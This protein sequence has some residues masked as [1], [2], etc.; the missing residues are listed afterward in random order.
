MSIILHGFFLLTSQEN[1]GVIFVRILKLLVCV[2]TW[3]FFFF[4]FSSFTL[5]IYNIHMC[6]SSKGMSNGRSFFTVV[7]LAYS[8]TKVAKYC[9]MHEHILVH[10]LVQPWDIALMPL[11]W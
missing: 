5:C 4:L 6:I 1:K 11:V 9:A 10:V 7:S 2:L 3:K 8:F